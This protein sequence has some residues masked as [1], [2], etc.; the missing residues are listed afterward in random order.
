[1][2]AVAAA[3]EAIAMAGIEPRRTGLERIAA[4]VHT[5]AGGIPALVEAAGVVRKRSVLA[6]PPLTVARYLPNMASTQVSLE[7]GLRG[8]SLTGTGAC[9]SG[10]LAL[11][12]AM[13]LIRRGEADVAIAG[14]AEACVT[15]IGIVGFD[16]LGVLSHRNHDP[17]GANRPFSVDRDG[18]VLSEGACVLLLESEAH[19]VR[20]NAAVL[21]EVVAGAVTSDGYHV[22]A[23]DPEGTWLARAIGL[24][25]E[26]AGVAPSDVHLISMHATASEAGDIAE[27]R[28]IRAAFGSLADTVPVTATKSMVGHLIGGAGALAAAGIV[29]GFARNQ[30]SPTVNL[31]QP[32]PDIHLNV[33]TDALNVQSVR[34]ALSIGLGFGGQNGVLLLRFPS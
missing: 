21:G 19:A 2:F 18:T 8:P 5:G 26:R 33:V 4:V 6:T 17:G 34:T 23:P 31:A 25:L 27:S 12:E 16:N 14:G 22:T 3:R 32:D 30:V 11:I 13:Q 10:T 28:A 1:Q 9:A 7:L 20:R 24:T 29:L 15:E